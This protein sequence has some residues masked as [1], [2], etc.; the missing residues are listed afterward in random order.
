MMVD[1]KNFPIASIVFEGDYRLGALQALSLDRLY[2]QRSVTEYTIILNGQDDDKLES[3]FRADVFPKLSDNLREKIKFLRW[4]DLL[5][6]AERDGYYDQQA[7]KLALG[8]YYDS[9]MY[10]M[11]DAKNHFTRPTKPEDFMADGKPAM[12]IVRANDTW[13]G[14]VKNSLAAVGN[15]TADP[16]VMMPS[17]TPFIMH[18]REVRGLR[19]FLTTKYDAALPQSLRKTGGTEFILYYAFIQNRFNDLYTDAPQPVRTLFTKWPQDPEVVKRYI[20]EVSDRNVPIFGLHRK[21][22]PQLTDGQKDMIASMWHRH[23]LSPW[24]NAEW[25]LQYD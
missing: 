3:C 18:T 24:E 5:G 14:Y 15:I 8:G 17:I 7:L 2:D 25:F 23:L 12:P 9:D 1:I 20:E 11:L 19:D 10:L 6:D 4:K 13:R 16:E 22:L 21:R